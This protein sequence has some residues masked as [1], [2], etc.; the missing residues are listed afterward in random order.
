M[1]DAIKSQEIDGEAIYAL[2]E[3]TNFEVDFNS[4]LEVVKSEDDSIS[5]PFGPKI[6]IKAAIKRLVGQ[7]F[8]QTI[9]PED[10][11]LEVQGIKSTP[12]CLHPCAAGDAAESNVLT[13]PLNSSPQLDAGGTET[14]LDGRE[15]AAEPDVI[16][17]Y[18]TVEKDQPVRLVL[19]KSEATP[20]GLKA[21]IAK[22]EGFDFVPDSDGLMLKQSFYDPAYPEASSSDDHD[23]W[24]LQVKLKGGNEVFLVVCISN[25]K[26]T[27]RL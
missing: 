19:N 6:K 1:I 23:R 2:A 25:Q 3:S 21:A 20:L 12:E 4:F 16:Y 27:Q 13:K 15:T 9:Q 26:V 24:N 17:H 8:G 5:L 11:A 22:T 14:Q 7:G 10:K 18:V